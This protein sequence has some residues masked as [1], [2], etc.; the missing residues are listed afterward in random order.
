MLSAWI[1]DCQANHPSCQQR[2]HPKLPTRVIDVGS[3]TA[4]PFLKITHGEVGRYLALS[5]R[6]GTLDSQ[7]KM[8]ITKRE[9]IGAFCRTIPFESFPLT[10]RHAIEASRSLGIQYLWIDSLCI[11][12]DDLQDWEIEAA[13]MGDI[14][15]NAYATLFAE[16][17]EHC[18]DGLFQTEE[19]KSIVTDWI[20]EIDYRNPQTNDLHWILCSFRHSYYPNS[21]SPEEAFCLVD[22]PISHLQN[23]GWIMQEEILSRR[24][25]C[26]STTELHWKC[27]SMSQ[28]ECGLKSLAN[29]R[30]TNDL[31]R[32]LLLTQR[33]DGSVTR[34][35]S[36]SSSNSKPTGNLNKSWKKLVEIY[37]Y[38]TQGRQ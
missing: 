35:L 5:H 7:H 2:M 4:Q 8:L 18:D 23:R 31:T 25:I 38:R 28:C 34:G 27:N 9:Y 21:L 1:N 16:R 24:K 30:F 19:D 29:T 37:G 22:K 12:Q 33:G 10:F 26:F 11:V 32:N 3:S 14:Y 36:A 15:E 6:W 13:R 17:A 20:Q